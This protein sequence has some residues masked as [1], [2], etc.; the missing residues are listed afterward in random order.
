M[1]TAV[2]P[3]TGRTWKEPVKSV[4]RKRARCF[5]LIAENG[6]VWAGS[7]DTPF[8]LRNGKTV[9]CEEMHGHFML[10]PLGWS[11]VNS[12][13]IGEQDVLAINIGGKTFYSNVQR[14]IPCASHNMA[15]PIYEGI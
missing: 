15:K 11:K 12:Y 9:L 3:P 14:G 8:T 5:L 13:F 1:L 6:A 7:W 10:T 2:D 4:G